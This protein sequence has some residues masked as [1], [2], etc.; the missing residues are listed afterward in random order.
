MVDLG[1][2]P[3]TNLLPIRRLRLAV[4]ATAPIRAAWVRFPEL[5]TE[6]L[7]Q[8]YTRLATD[9]YLCQSVAGRFR[10]ELTVD[11]TG[12]VLDCPGLWIAEARADGLDTLA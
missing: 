12:L 2:S 6:V 9:R 11:T 4:G 5:T 3:S 7:E 8:T 10:R 1:F